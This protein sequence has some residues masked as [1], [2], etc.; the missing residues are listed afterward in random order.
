MPGTGQ[1]VI[2]VMPAYNA[3][4]T[5]EAT[6]QAID[7]HY[8][9]EVILV[10]D[11][12]RDGTVAVAERLALR[13][14]RHEKNLGYG[15][16]QKTCYRDAIQRGADIVVMLHPDG[17]YDPTLLPMLVHPLANGDADIVIGSRFL[18]PGAARRGGMPLYRF[19]AN[20]L[21]TFLEN[22][23]LRQQLSEYHTGYRAYSRRFLTTVP[24]HQNSNEFCFDSE[25][26]IQAI[27]FRQ[28]LVEVP[29]ATKYFH[30]ASSASLGQC[31]RYGVM[32]VL[33]LLKFI[34]H[35]QQIVKSELFVEPRE[36]EET[37]VC[38]MLTRNCGKI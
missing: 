3:A 16:N 30:G 33:T 36:S 13:V 29:I 25:I 26:L 19:V 32:T 23:V 17:Q 37:P 15:G 9:D 14:I 11:C 4:E 24:F 35:R 22:L 8:V 20:R 27:A 18:M 12:S 34:L 21:L 5:L 10:D 38:P 2:V 6:Y 7:T 28:R 31:V 1:R